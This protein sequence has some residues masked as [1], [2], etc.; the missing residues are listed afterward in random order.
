MD[1]VK[2][3]IWQFKTFPILHYITCWRGAGGRV[4][5]SITEANYKCQHHSTGLFPHAS[6]QLSPTLVKTVPGH[7]TQQSA[8]LLRD[9]TMGF[10]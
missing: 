8:E 5:V 7:I 2:A 6:D 10:T 1:F 3:R 9:R 4:L